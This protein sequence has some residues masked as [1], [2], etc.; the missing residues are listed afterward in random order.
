MLQIISTYNSVNLIIND[1][2]N[3]LSISDMNHD[4]QRYREIYH[5]DN[6]YFLFPLVNIANVRIGQE[7]TA[8]L[9]FLCPIINANVNMR[10]VG[11]G[12]N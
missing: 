2:N 6:I 1:N 9:N 12:R 7:I 5:R 10:I 11:N 3:F 8:H 4:I